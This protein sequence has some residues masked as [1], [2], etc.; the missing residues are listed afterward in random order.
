M[1]Q[2]DILSSLIFREKSLLIDLILSSLELL[3]RTC[4]EEMLDGF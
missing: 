3:K 4:Q 2:F 1:K